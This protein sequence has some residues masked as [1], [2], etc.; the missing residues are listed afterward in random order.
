MN[1]MSDIDRDFDNNDNSNSSNNFMRGAVERCPVHESASPF[2]S[3]HT[4]HEGNRR[5][6]IENE[7]EL[8]VQIDKLVSASSEMA[9]DNSR[10]LSQ[11]KFLETQTTSQEYYLNVIKCGFDSS[12]QTRDELED[13]LN[14]V[15]EEINKL[16]KT[17]KKIETEKKKEEEM[18]NQL[19]KKVIK[20]EEHI[21]RKEKELVEDKNEERRIN[22]KIEEEKKKVNQTM[23]NDLIKEQN[24]IQEEINNYKEEIRN[25]L[26]NETNRMHNILY[27]IDINCDTHKT[28]SNNLQ[29]VL[30]KMKIKIKEEQNELWKT[31]REIENKNMQIY[32]LQ[33][34]INEEKIKEKEIDI[35][36]NSKKEELNELKNKEQLNDTCILNVKEEME[37]I[38]SDY[39]EKILQVK[40]MEKQL[41]ENYQLTEQ[42]IMQLYKDYDDRKKNIY[43]LDN[44]K[45]D[46]D[47]AEKR[48]MKE[49]VDTYS[50]K[51]KN[52][53]DSKKVQFEKSEK[54]KYDELNKQ[55]DDELRRKQDLVQYYREL[56]NKHEDKEKEK[57]KYNDKDEA[58]NN[59]ERVNDKSNDV[60]SYLVSNVNNLE[61]D[62]K[63][64]YDIPNR[65]NN[66]KIMENK[67]TY[68]KNGMYNNINKYKLY[69]MPD[70]YKFG[71]FDVSSPS[72]IRKSMKVP[73]RTV[74]SPHI[75]RLL[76]KIKSRK[77]CQPLVGTKQSPMNQVSSNANRRSKGS[78]GDNGHSRSSNGKNNSGK[79]FSD[80]KT[81]KNNG[82][83]DLFQHL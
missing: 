64:V 74:K 76:E 73:C 36:I 43:N 7:K 22:E 56:L 3:I 65:T 1:D 59:K 66:G 31:E 75:A 46:I 60:Y 70:Q 48:K 11:T 21:E 24:S 15:K 68:Q 47:S 67:K 17:I 28:I 79:L 69:N 6:I 77:E 53:Y 39:N 42:K 20:L 19:R 45:I 71:Y 26:L 58:S 14:N 80:M 27:H 82:S 38:E 37:K 72:V 61:E 51:M 49:D 40:E 32:E 4:V 29:S 13:S 34:K 25:V 83:F 10:L 81:P 2:L 78:M 30:D 23:I 55:L 12:V 54:V 50:E 33:E 9:C 62:P 35:S 44:H 41:N 16:V 57:N 5:T 8:K 18:C 52:E 63:G